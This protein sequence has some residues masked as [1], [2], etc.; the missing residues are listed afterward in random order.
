M[1]GG[2]I[3]GSNALEKAKAMIE[4]GFIS[5]AIVGVTN[6]T[7]RPE[8]QFQFQGLNRLNQ[9]FQTKSFSSDGIYF[10]TKN[11]QGKLYN[12]MFIQTH[13]L[14]INKNKHNITYQYVHKP[15]KPPIYILFECDLINNFFKFTFFLA[16][17]YNRSE[18]CIV[19][20]LQKASEAKRSYGTLLSVRSVHFGDHE[21]HITEHN[22]N[23]LKSLLLDSYKQANID[24]ASV[25]YIEAY[26]SGI[27]VILTC[28]CQHII[29]LWLT[30][31]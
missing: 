11:E 20:Y 24:P 26:G 27:K 6:L 31:D 21:G 25:E 14:S 8:I 7:L 12:T 29:I 2:W 15:H 4:N 10:L 23:N 22:R 19:M 3:C 1:D 30:N 5:S 13:I 9:S 16:D 17:G 18:A 28:V